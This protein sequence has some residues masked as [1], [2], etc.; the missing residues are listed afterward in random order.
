VVRRESNQAYNKEEDFKEKRRLQRKGFTFKDVAVDALRGKERRLLE[1]KPAQRLLDYLNLH[2]PRMQLIGASATAQPALVNFL[3]LRAKKYDS[4]LK[5]KVVSSRP[6]A[7]LTKGLRSRG[8][9]GVGV[10]SRIRHRMLI[11]K[12]ADTN[13]KL[14]NVLE[15]YNAD[16]PWSVLM[17]VGNT[18]SVAGWVEKLRFRGIA[19]AAPLHE[20]L[21]FGGEGA[22]G[23]A[24]PATL[25]ARHRALQ[26]RFANHTGERPFV[27][28][29]QATCRGIDLK[30]V[31][32]VYLTALPKDTDEYQHLAGR[33]GREGRTGKVVSFFDQRE[34]LAALQFKRDLG[35]KMAVAPEELIPRYSDPEP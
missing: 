33:S 31:D 35:I 30:G 27:V 20:L 10:P 22:A 7:P 9:A 13:T 3:S 15:V 17:A 8:V 2:K 12:D 23:R 5:I 26:E 6:A 14:A 29:T 1:L 34:V 18:E 11:N 24:D 21:G 4:F 28:T 19:G 16:A 25:L 32:A